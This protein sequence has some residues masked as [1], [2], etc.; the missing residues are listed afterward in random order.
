MKTRQIKDYPGNAEHE[1]RLR[2]EAALQDVNR[3]DGPETAPDPDPA[4]GHRE[5]EVSEQR[6]LDCGRHGR[7]RWQLGTA[8]AVFSENQMASR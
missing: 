4:P 6:Q 8:N 5:P 2:T 7:R 1:D 3:N